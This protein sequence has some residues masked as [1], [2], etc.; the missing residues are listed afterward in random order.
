VCWPRRT[1]YPSPA[2]PAPL[3]LRRLEVRPHLLHGVERG[4]V[5]RQGLDPEPMCMVG[6][7]RTHQLA[8]MGGEVIPEHRDRPADVPA[9]RPKELEDGER[10]HR[11]V[12][13]RSEEPVVG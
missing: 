4:R 5:G 12:A 2:S 1:R 8:A 13:Q 3:S 9:E 7:V 10:L 6:D 11:I